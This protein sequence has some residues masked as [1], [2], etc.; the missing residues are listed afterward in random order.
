M[1]MHCL[2]EANQAI[3]YSSESRWMAGMRKLRLYQGLG[4]IEKMAGAA[5]L[6]VPGKQK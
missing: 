6:S 1:A 2:T 4:Q 5:H 3:Q